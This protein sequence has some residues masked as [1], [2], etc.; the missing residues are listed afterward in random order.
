M[1]HVSLTPYRSTEINHLALALSKAQGAYK[2]LIPN[3]TYRGERYANLEAVFDATRDALSV[4]ALALYQYE[5]FLDAPD[6]VNLWTNLLH[7]SGQSIS[8]GVR[9]IS[10]KTDKETAAVKEY[11]ARMQVVRLL[12]I[13]PSH[14]DPYMHDD[15]G[16]M[17][18]DGALLEELEA[19]R[20]YQ[21]ECISNEQYMQLLAALKGN[22]RLTR[23]VLTKHKIKNLDEMPANQFLKAIDAIRTIR[24]SE[25]D[26]NTDGR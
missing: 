26:R 23:Q 22:S 15:N 18:A 1:D 24:N 11:Q 21:E 20:E 14:H 19:K 12:G 5:Q 4:N 25:V 10:C 9:I 13:A 17:Q 7:E 6:A 16:E 3:Q 2:K 8:S